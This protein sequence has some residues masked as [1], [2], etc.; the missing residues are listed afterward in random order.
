MSISFGS[1]N[2]GLPK[3]IVQRL[4]QAERIPVT[5]M[6]NRKAKMME[7]AGLV[8]QL[9]KLVEGIKADVDAN[10]STRSLKE[11]K[12]ETKEDI[13]DVQVD[14]NVV[15]PGSHQLE[16]IS[17]AQSAS[18]MTN[19]FEDPDESYVGVGYIRYDLPNGEQ[20]EIYINQDNA[21][22]NGIARKIN[23]TSNGTITGQL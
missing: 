7:K 21:T 3:D 1:I 16:V 4:M 22:L 12:V 11:I 13:I 10:N 20:E 19:G 17:L 8:D 6:E 14:K 15:L 9:G 5:K 18:A 2:T 23:Q